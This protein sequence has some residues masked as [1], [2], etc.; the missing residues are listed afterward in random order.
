MSRKPCNFFSKPGGCRRGNM[1]SFS[2]GETGSSPTRSSGSNRPPNARVQQAN[3][4]NAPAGVCN[5]YWSTG[6]CNREFECRFRHT[7]NPAVVTMTADASSSEAS[8][9]SP[10][11]DIIAPFLTEAGL[12]KVNG[13][14]TDV[15]FL[16]PAS[17]LSPNEVHNHLKRFLYDDFRFRKTFDVYAFLT[18]ISSANSS[19]SLWVG[20]IPNLNVTAGSI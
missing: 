17:P 18:P 3:Y 1:C 8:T 2:H 5:F 20:F 13:T 4:A 9:A 6:K 14:G 12:S 7:I 10:A 19:N 16:N 11:V 15:F